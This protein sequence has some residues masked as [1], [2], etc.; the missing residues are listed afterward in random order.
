MARRSTSRV[1]THGTSTLIADVGE[2]L[3]TKSGGVFCLCAGGGDI[4]SS[5]SPAHGLYFHDTRFLD[6]AVLR[7]GDEPLSVLL[8]SA[9]DDDRSVSELTNPDLE[10]ARGRVVPKQQIGI[11]RERK[12][13]KRANEAIFIRN[14]GLEKVTIELGLEFAAG[15]ESMFAIR[16]AE[17]G[18]RGTLCKPRW[19]E[20]RLE[21]R[22]DGADGRVR[23]TK[24][25]FDPKPSRTGANATAHYRLELAPAATRCIRIEIE[26]ADT[27]PGTLE[28]EPTAWRRNPTFSSVHVKSDNP[29][30]NR[31]LERSF[32][33]L[34]MLATR[35]RGEIFFAAGVPWFV[36]LF[37]RDS[38]V[39][40]LET[41]AYNPRIAAET[42]ILLAHYQGRRHD[43]WRDEEPGKILHELRVGEMPNLGEVPQTPYYG[44]ADATPLFLCLM[45]EYV[46]W[47]GDLG[48]FRKLEPNVERALHWLD[49]IADHDGDGFADY[50]SH[51]EKGLANQGWKDSGNSIANS[52][53][54]VAEPPVALV[55]MQGYVYRARL[56]TAWLYRL[57]GRRQEA[58]QLERQARELRKRFQGA[59]WLPERRYLAVALQKGGRPAEAISSNPGQA[60]WSGIVNARHARAVA[61][62]LLAKPM[63]SGW[64][65][66]TMAEGEAA[67]NPLDYQVGAV[68]PHDNAMIASGLKRYGYSDDA[69]QV[70]GAIYQ[71][72][73]RFP[74][75][76]L[77]EVFAGFDRGDSPEPVRY[78]VACSPQAWAAGAI[79]Y[80]LRIVLGLEP[81]AT[82]D[83]LRIVR[84]VLPDWLE[85]VS[86]RGLRVG[87]ATVDLLF[88][89]HHGETSVVVLEQHGPLHVLVEC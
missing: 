48:L 89:R 78:P 28:T 27:G 59:Y 32:A 39:T 22:Y 67:Y 25:S 37:G 1:L 18:R 77:P 60:L 21:F 64:G 87:K 80:M 57:S 63:F 62:T 84:P 7:L 45:A 16:G 35:E 13:G 69:L 54:S 40:A 9:V 73:T 71:A 24:L 14:F 34:E 81:D 33:D 19:T 12:L 43:E 86:V 3:T 52:D 76:R 4:D 82:E 56:D 50:V 79:P 29:L 42:L 30:F 31:V 83:T 20:N 46:R 36:C 70:F 68:W 47:T 85:E 15:F 88:R 17:V 11:R 74:S 61:R 23:T 51:S 58:E 8:S 66:R 72:A 38:I 53:G 75:Y 65:I 49:T 55:E 44:S 5:V 26:L 2:T 10:L 41:V 6:R